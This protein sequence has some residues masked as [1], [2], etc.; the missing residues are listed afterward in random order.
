VYNYQNVLQRNYV[1]TEKLVGLVWVVAAEAPCNFCREVAESRALHL[2]FN[3]YL[4]RRYPS[5]ANE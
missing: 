1:I 3:S 5:V 2:H 4:D